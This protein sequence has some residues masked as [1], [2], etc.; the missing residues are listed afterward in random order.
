MISLKNKK[1]IVGFSLVELSI[2]LVIVGLLLSGVISSITSFIENSRIAKAK[3]ELENIRETIIGFTIVHARLPCPSNKNCNAQN[4]YEPDGLEDCGVSWG[5]VP[6][7]TLGI[8]A[9]DP[10]GS[11]YVYRIDTD[12]ADVIVLGDVGDIQVLDGASGNPVA[13]QVAAIVYSAGPNEGQGQGAGGIGTSAD[14]AENYDLDCNSTGIKED[15][16]LVYKNFVPP[17]SAQDEFDD[18]MV[19]ISEYL[20]KARLSQAGVL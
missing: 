10:W 18:V 13:N 3:A 7:Q 4:K 12:F 8:N 19:W 11:N 15:D 1:Q 20:V 16:I 5:F 2:V 6:F 9:R 17:G 14:E